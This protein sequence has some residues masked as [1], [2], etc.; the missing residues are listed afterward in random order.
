VSNALLTRGLSSGRSLSMLSRGL[1]RPAV[2]QFRRGKIIGKI[3][4]SSKLS[5]ALWRGK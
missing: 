2:I 3:L 5:G 4:I 1:L